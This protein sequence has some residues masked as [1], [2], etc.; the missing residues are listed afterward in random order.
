MQPYIRI[1]VLEHFRATVTALGQDPDRLLH[2]ANIP[3]SALEISGSYIPHQNLRLLLHYAAE[4]TDCP[5]FAIEMTRRSGIGSLGVTGLLMM[6]ADNVGQAWE[7]LS[8]FFSTQDTF[9]VVQLRR[10][11]SSGSIAY[12]FPYYDRLGC[13]QAADL[14]TNISPNIMRQL[15]GPQWRAQAMGLP[16]SQ[17]PDLSIYRHLPVDKLIFDHP[18]HELFFDQAWLDRPLE[19]SNPKMSEL[20]NVYF[21]SVGKGRDRSSKD[22]VDSV[23]RDLLASGNCT[24]QQTAS[25]MSISVRTLQNHLKI[26]G[27]SFQQLLDTARKDIAMHHLRR[28]DIPLSELA[29]I[30]GYSEL[31]A[32][33]RAFTRW[34]GVSPKNLVKQQGL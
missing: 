17:P 9:A 15:C 16:Y 8:R 13:K 10:G 4:A 19:N 12:T 14:A 22:K 25:L 21:S 24:L 23:I 32:F 28:K 34:F 27:S 29:I 18:A 7:N 1:G 20:F 26:E 30:L 31:S 33:T 2:L 5:H 6:Q 11:K 3:P